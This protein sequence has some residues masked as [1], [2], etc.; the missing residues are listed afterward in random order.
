[1][2][3]LFWKSVLIASY[4]A[5]IAATTIIIIPSKQSKLDAADLLTNQSPAKLE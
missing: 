2:F 5:C 1:M 3:P 4:F